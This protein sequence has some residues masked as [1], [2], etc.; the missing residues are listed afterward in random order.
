[1]KIELR[2]D[3]DESCDIYLDNLYIYDINHIDDGWEGMR[4]TIEL[5]N[6]LADALGIEVVDVG[7][8]LV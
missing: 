5:L 1:M 2:W 3:D 7:D 8:P 4:R 6:N